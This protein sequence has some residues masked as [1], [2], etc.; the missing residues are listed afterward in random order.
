MVIHSLLLGIEVML[1]RLLVTIGGIEE[2]GGPII[3]SWGHLEQRLR[4]HV[5]LGRWLG[6]AHANITWLLVR[7]LLHPESLGRVGVHRLHRVWALLSCR[8]EG[9]LE[10]R[11]GDVRLLERLCGR[12]LCI[13]VLL[14]IGLNKRP[15][16]L[17][18]C[19]WLGVGEGRGGGWEW[20]S[21][22]IFAAIALLALPTDPLASNYNGIAA[23]VAWVA[24]VSSAV[25]PRIASL[26]IA[27][28]LTEHSLLGM[29][30][31]LPAL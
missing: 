12:R 27:T 3:I 16:I 22:H 14:V 17:W 24:L 4:S 26:P 15:L 21:G 19:G 23:G 5:C 6:L 1:L 31:L 20:G 29:N 10:L 18:G 30:I 11:H 2:E 8:H 7:W 13:W 25:A 28:T 9:L